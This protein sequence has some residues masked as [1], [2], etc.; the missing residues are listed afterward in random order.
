MSERRN[1][2]GGKAR[3]RPKCS[4]VKNIRWILDREDVLVWWI[5]LAQDRDKWRAPLHVVMVPENAG[6]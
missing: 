4:W 2:Y 1:M 5:V 6:K 3:G